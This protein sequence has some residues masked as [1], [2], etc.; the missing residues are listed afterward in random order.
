MG[1]DA[2]AALRLHYALEDRIQED[3][4]T[5]AVMEKVQLPALDAFY[6]HMEENG[7]NIDTEEFAALAET[8]DEEHTRLFGELIALV[9]RI[10]RRRHASKGLKFTRPDFVRDIL[11]SKDGYNL[12]PLKFTPSTERKDNPADRIPSTDAKKHLVYF[13]HIPWVKLYQ[14]YSKIGKMR[15]TCGFRPRRPLIPK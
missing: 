4:R 11:F 7:V 8:L 12:K 5:V 9:P 15:S 14:D 3:P 10:I 2:D 13:D 6:N 1:G